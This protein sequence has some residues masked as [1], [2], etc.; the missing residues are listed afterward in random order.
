MSSCVC[1]RVYVF[2][3]SLVCM[4]VV[5][6]VF[7]GVCAKVLAAYMLAIAMSTLVCNTTTMAARGTGGF[8]HEL[9]ALTAR[10]ACIPQ[11]GGLPFPGVAAASKRVAGNCA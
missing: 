4:R 10:E 6:G 9:E 3:R 2:A 8:Q 5:W 7:I 11:D 1:V